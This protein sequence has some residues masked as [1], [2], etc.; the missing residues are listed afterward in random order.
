M[1]STRSPNLEFVSTVRRTD[2]LHKAR[3]RICYQLRGSQFIDSCFHI[4]WQYPKAAKIL[5]QLNGGLMI[6]TL[7]IQELR[8]SFEE[9]RGRVEQLGRFL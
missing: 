1:L 9:L 5:S 4:R 6:E 7:S 2:V 8:T 3:R